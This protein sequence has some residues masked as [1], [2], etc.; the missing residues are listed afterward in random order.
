MLTGCPQCG[1]RIRGRHHV[2]GVVNLGQTYTPPDFCDKCGG[3]F[4]WAGRKARIYELQNRIDEEKLDPAAELII[5]EQ[6]EALLNPD[7]DDHEQVT[8]WKRIRA[9]A[10][11]ILERAATAPIV[12]TLITAA[13]KSQLP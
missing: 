3:P 10:P 4:P 2:P 11:G 13:I 7:I 6:L 5:R 8:R 9:A 1:N 12:E